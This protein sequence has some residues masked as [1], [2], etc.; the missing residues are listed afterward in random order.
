MV[1]D[2]TSTMKGNENT[3]SSNPVASGLCKLRNAFKGK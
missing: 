1:T 3:L 2:Q